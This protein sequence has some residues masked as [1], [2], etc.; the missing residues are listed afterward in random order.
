MES[1]TASQSKDSD[2]ISE[3]ESLPDS[4]MESQEEIKFDEEE[5]KKAE[6][7]K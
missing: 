2:L 5:I 4:E 7:F 1:S 6:E 3:T